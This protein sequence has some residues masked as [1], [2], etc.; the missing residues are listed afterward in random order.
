MK[1]LKVGINYAS[2]SNIYPHTHAVSFV[3]GSYFRSLNDNITFKTNNGKVI[4]WSLYI[5]ED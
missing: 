1:G 3:N 5:N 4:W 2:A